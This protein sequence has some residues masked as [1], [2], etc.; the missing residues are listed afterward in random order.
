M[1]FQPDTL[2]GVNVLSRFEPGRAWVNGSLHECSLV[3]PWRGSVAPWSVGAFEELTADHFSALAE[4]KPEVVLFGSGL[5]LRFP[6]A[7]LLRSLI[8]RRIGVETMDSAAAARTYNVLAAEGRAVVVALLMETG[9][10]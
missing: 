5:R 7:A 3:V 1:K 10:A 8:E 2:A 4:F 6:P 9:Q